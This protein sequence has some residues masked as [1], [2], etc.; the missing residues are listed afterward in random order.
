MFFNPEKISH[1]DPVTLEIVSWKEI[2]LYL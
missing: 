1:N 2:G